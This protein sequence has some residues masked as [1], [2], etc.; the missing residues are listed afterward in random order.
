MYCVL[1]DRVSL[2]AEDDFEYG[3]EENCMSET[4][5]VTEYYR[6]FMLGIIA[7]SYKFCDVQLL[8]CSLICIT[9]HAALWMLTGVNV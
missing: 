3:G 6:K 5:A 7:R 9:Y 4:S 2:A 1:I 8:I